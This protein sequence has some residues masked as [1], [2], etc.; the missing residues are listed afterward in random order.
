MQVLASSIGWISWLAEEVLSSDPVT[1]EFG[2]LVYFDISK[3]KGKIIINPKVMHTANS[4]SQNS[5]KIKAIEL[6]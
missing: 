2:S 6:T 4:I 3:R 1:L 5:E